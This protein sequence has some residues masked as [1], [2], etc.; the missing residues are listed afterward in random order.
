M[1]ELVEISF[2]YFGGILFQ[3]IVSDLLD[4]WQFYLKT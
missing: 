2:A 4:D 3:T 1:W